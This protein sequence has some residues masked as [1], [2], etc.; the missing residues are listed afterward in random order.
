VFPDPINLFGVTFHLFGIFAAVSIFLGYHETE[1]EMRRLSIALNILPDLAFS[2]LVCAFLGARLLFVITHLNDY[3]LSPLDALKFWEGGLVLYGGLMGG[4]FGGFLF[5]CVRKLSFAKLSDPVAL[6][7]ASGLAFSRLGCLAAGCCYGKQTSLPWGIV[8]SN[9][10]TLAKPLHIPLHPTQLYSFIIGMGIYF[11][12]LFLR[13]RK[14]FEG[15]L[16]LSY[17]IMTS[18]AR[19]FVDYFRADSQFFTSLTVFFVFVL[20]SVCYGQLK[21]KQWRKIMKLPMSRITVFILVASLLAACGIIKTQK[22]SRGL[23]ILG[24]DVNQI[25]KDKTTEKEII[26]TFGPPTKI[27]DTEDGKEFFYEYTKS[28]GPQWNLVVSVGGDT[29]TKTLLV[30]LDKKGVVTDYAYKKS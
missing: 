25:V 11:V 4:L 6:G 8:F 15:E 24:S 17:F 20:S 30:W 7:I 12:L 13:N 29:V 2:V 19:L 22:I 1:R 26:K 14:T 16:L 28:G 5:C 27:R 3:A 9:P 23:D 18:A 10:N 21:V